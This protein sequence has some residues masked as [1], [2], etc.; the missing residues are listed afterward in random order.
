[1]ADFSAVQALTFDLFGT[2]LD[3]GGSLIPPLRPFLQEKNATLSAEAFWAQWRYRQRI[4]QY[5]DTIMMLGHSG[6]QEVARRAFVYVLRNNRIETT[7]DEVAA[8]MRNWQQL[9][10]FPEVTPALARLRSRYKLVVLSNGEPDFLQHLAANRVQ[11]AFD[12]IFSVNTVGAFKP[13]P[14]VYR[15]AALHLELAV[16]QCLMVSAN[17]FDTVGARSCGFRAVYVNRYNLPVE[18]HPY[19]PDQIVGNFTELADCLLAG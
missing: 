10:S 11:W 19:Q 15:R 7:A 9:S 13:H 2:I 16:G 5:Q 12:D 1:M 3:L 17:A 14:A 6:Y 4:E 8:F 18:D